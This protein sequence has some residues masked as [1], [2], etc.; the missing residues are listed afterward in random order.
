VKDEELASIAAWTER[1]GRP[2]VFM[3]VFFDEIHCMSFARMQRAIV[4]GRVYQ[5]GDYLADAET[6]AG[7]KL[8]HR[9]FLPDDAHR[10]ASVIFPDE[11][12]ARV[13]VLEDGS[14]IPH[15][16]FRPATATVADAAVIHREI[17]F[18][19]TL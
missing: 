2:Q 8:Y 19:A 13:A 9:F 14:V 1:T 16:E 4:D 5:A 17:M 10:Y 11:S 12:L 3:Q 6:G 18:P 15:I 7:G